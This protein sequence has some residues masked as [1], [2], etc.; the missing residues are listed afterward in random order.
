MGTGE[1]GGSHPTPQVGTTTWGH[2]RM[3]CNGNFLHRAR[4]T[5]ATI[6]LIAGGYLV[7]S[8]TTAEPAAGEGWSTQVLPGT[9]RAGPAE[10]PVDPPQYVGASEKRKS[11][12]PAA[13]K[14]GKG[15]GEEDLFRSGPQ[16]DESYHA[17]GNVDIYGKKSAVEPPRPPI[18]LGRQ[19]YT[20]GQYDKSSTIFGGLNDKRPL[21]AA[22]AVDQS[23][24]LVLKGTC[25]F[26]G[27]DIKSY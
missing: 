25:L 19:Q 23:K 17:Q 11:A 7:M 3:T 13:R 14:R 10:D 15:D 16:Y 1:G 24:I 18:E 4:T 12:D 8:G 2:F 27:I 22:T 20:S 6:A 26:G 21:P 5:T 9:L